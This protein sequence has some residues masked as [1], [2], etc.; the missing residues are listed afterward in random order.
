MGGGGL[1]VI[2]CFAAVVQTTATCDCE[3]AVAAAVEAVRQEM[4][5]D[6]AAA[7]AE[8]RLQLGKERR[9]S[10]TA[11]ADGG[12]VIIHAGGTVQ[13]GNGGNLNVGA[14]SSTS[15]DPEEPPPSPPSP[16]PP[17]PPSSP[18][19]APSPP[20]ATPPFL[21]LG[22]GLTAP[23]QCTGLTTF[24]ILPGCN[25][26]WTPQIYADWWCAR[27]GA[28]A[29]HG[30]QL[31]TTASHFDLCKIDNGSQDAIMTNVGVF[32]STSVPFRTTSGGE[33]AQQHYGCWCLTDLACLP[34]T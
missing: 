16:P 5:E 18:P 19:S 31:V 30:W 9:L 6:K 21:T 20:P 32:P 17:P 25:V 3:A 24:G 33:C 7:L 23:S 34:S 10:E 8:L 2:C 28:G 29:A 11:S 26:N 27:M 14:G 13:I 15:P 1:F 22:S 12:Q 4:R